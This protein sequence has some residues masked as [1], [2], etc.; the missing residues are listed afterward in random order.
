[1]SLEF[2]SSAGMLSA[3]PPPAATVA[4][5]GEGAA[6]R[7]DALV[8]I[9]L[10]GLRESELVRVVCAAEDALS[11]AA[12]GNVPRVIISRVIGVRNSAGLSFFVFWDAP[13]MMVCGCISMN[14]PIRAFEMMKHGFNSACFCRLFSLSKLATRLEV[15]V[16]VCGFNVG[17]ISCDHCTNYTSRPFNWGHARKIT[18]KCVSRRQTRT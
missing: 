15:N 8:S 12:V 3:R 18:P 2:R 7:E 9:G 13:V 11:E 4:A 10:R 5:I 16:C 1:M 17:E 14:F 6:K